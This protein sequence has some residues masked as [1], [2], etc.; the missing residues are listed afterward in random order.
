MWGAL[1]GAVGAMP[2]TAPALPWAAGSR[3]HGL[4]ALKWIP[5]AEQVIGL[6]TCHC[7]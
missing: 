1:H 3:V 5:R 6:V 2:P 4:M 7:S